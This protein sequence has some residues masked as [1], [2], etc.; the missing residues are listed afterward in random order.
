MSD[1]SVSHHHVHI[2]ESGEE[3]PR[4]IDHIEAKQQLEKQTIFYA[5]PDPIDLTAF[6]PDTDSID[7]SLSRLAL[8]GN[9]SRFTNLLSLCFRSNLLKT[10]QSEE[11]RVE[12]GL[13]KIQELDFYDNQIE[14]IENLNQFE[15][16]LENLDMSFNRFKKLENVERLVKL[17]KLYLVHNQIGKI[18]NLDTLV[19][20][21]LLEL[22]D[23]KLRSIENLDMLK[24]LTQV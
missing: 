9:F 11:F 16:S 3:S 6:S 20:L 5:V 7:F 2:S 22:G 19:G 8:L 18:E 24:N 10:L 23:N 1:E 21:E 15:G 17:K 13:D 4:Q 14:V 12:H